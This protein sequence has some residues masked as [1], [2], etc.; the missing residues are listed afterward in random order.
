MLKTLTNINK[1]QLLP[2]RVQSRHMWRICLFPFP[3]GTFCDHTWI[4]SQQPKR[5]CGQFLVVVDIIDI[6]PSEL[7]KAIPLRHYIGNLIVTPR[8]RLQ[9]SIWT[10]RTARDIILKFCRGKLRISND[11]AWWREN[12]LEAKRQTWTFGTIFLARASTM[13]ILIT[14]ATGNTCRTRMPPS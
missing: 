14:R 12:L 7:C 6:S 3:S 8:P 1:H 9:V 5:H 13:K 10:P 11:D 4:G 2:S